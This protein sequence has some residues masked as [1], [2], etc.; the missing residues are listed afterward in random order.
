MVLQVE[1][2]EQSGM[3]GTFLL[4]QLLTRVAFKLDASYSFINASCVIDLNLEVEA[5]KEARSGCS[6]LGCRVRVDL[7][8]Q[9]CELEI[10]EILFMVDPQGGSHRVGCGCTVWSFTTLSECGLSLSLGLRPM[11]THSSNQEMKSN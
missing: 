7:I 6:S 4:L 2:T 8:G 3:Q 10:S 5:F 1:H 9:D 11:K